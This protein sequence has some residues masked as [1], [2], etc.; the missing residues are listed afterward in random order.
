[1]DHFDEHG[2]IEISVAS[3]RYRSVYRSAAARASG[4]APRVG[5]L[6]AP[7]SRCIPLIVVEHLATDV[8]GDLR[9]PARSDVTAAGG[10][11]RSGGGTRPDGQGGDRHG[12]PKPTI[13]R[14]SH[15]TSDLD[16]TC[17]KS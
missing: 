11:V 6:A 7:D 9:K 3:V 4:L 2:E 1:V 13:H 10:P 12:G 14:A 16:F 8:S 17:R 5:V 15:V